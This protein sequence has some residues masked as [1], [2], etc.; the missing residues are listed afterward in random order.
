MN[1]EEYLRTKLGNRNPFTVPKGYFD[2]LADSVMQQL[3]DDC[4]MQQLPDDRVMQ[5]LPDDR[6]HSVIRSIRPWLYAAAC[7]AILIVSVLFVSHQSNQ[8]TQQQAA[9]NN[10]GKTETL[11]DNY[12]DDMADYAM[13]DNEEIYLYLADL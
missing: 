8:P 3:S 13:V 10:T 12:I 7:I 5:Q 6:K 2:H 1:E 4:V 9:V 11:S